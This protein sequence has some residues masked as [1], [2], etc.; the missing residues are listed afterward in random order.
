MTYQEVLI[1]DKD[2]ELMEVLSSHLEAECF[3]VRFT[4]SGE[5]TLALARDI[6]AIVLLNSELED[7]PGLEVC[8]RLREGRDTSEVPIIMLSRSAEGD[9]R[10]ESL[11]AGA[12]DYVPRPVNPREL[13]ARIRAVLRRSRPADAGEALIVGDIE[14]NRARHI[15]IGRG[16]RVDLEATEFRLIEAFMKNPGRVMS[17]E[18]L[19]SIVWGHQSD[20]SVRTVDVHIRRLRQAL[21]LNDAPAPIRTVRSAG[22]SLDFEL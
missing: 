3:D 19:L 21:H 6:P 16:A 18:Q 8:R 22:Y 12:D 17:R 7:L 15:V 2:V 4:R 1:A 11:E 14:L 9:D 13:I 20:I 10:L 5:R